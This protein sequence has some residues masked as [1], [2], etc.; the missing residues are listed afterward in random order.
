[1]VKACSFV[2]LLN[3]LRCVCFTSLQQTTS[4]MMIVIEAYQNCS[5]LYCVPQLLALIIY[6]HSYERFLQMN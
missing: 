6:A 3:M 1:M 2:C 5:V 4:T